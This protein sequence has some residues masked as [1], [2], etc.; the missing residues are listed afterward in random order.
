MKIDMRQ[1]L[2]S[3]FDEAAEHIE[4]MESALLALSET[5]HNAELLNTVFRAAHSIKGASATFDVRSVASFT[6]VLESLLERMRL[7]DVPVTA[8]RIETMLQTIDVLQG[9]LSAEQNGTPP[10]DNVDVLVGKLHAL[11]GTDGDAAATEPVLETRPESSDES[12]EFEIQFTPS[13]RIF[14][15][16]LDPLLLLDDL[17]EC[18]TITEICIDDSRLPELDKMDP[19][20]CYLGWSVRL[21][22]TQ[23]IDTVRDVFVFVDEETR[24]EVTTANCDEQPGQD[25]ETASD[26]GDN[27]TSFSDQTTNADSPT[28]G[29]RSADASL[30]RR[31]SIRVDAGR[32]DKLIN[33]VGELVIGEAMTRQEFFELDPAGDS[34]G[35]S[36]LSRTVTE[37]QEL[38]L[39]LRMVPIAGTFQ[40]TKRI[41]YDVSRKVGKDVVFETEGTETELD[42]TVVDQLGDPLMHMVRNAVDHGIEAANVRRATG[43]PEAGRVVLRA[44]HRSGNVC[45]ELEDDG[46][47]L[48]REAILRKAIERDIVSEADAP[49][50]TDE[51]VWALI[52]APGFSTAATVT[53][54]SGRGVGMDVV[55]RNIEAING[56]ISITSRAGRGSTFHI[57]L[58]LTMAIVDGLAV[59]LSDETFIVPLLAVV[60]SLRPDQEHVKTIKGDGEVVMVRGEPIPLVRPHRVFNHA[61]A[62]A[63]PWEALVVV[64]ENQGRHLALLVDDLEGDVQAVMKSLEDNYRKVDGVAG[65]TILG[66]GQVG[67][68]LDIPGLDRIRRG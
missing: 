28:S 39:S 2:R 33:M 21:K 15:L 27:S 52:F 55:K 1:F 65:A 61:Y 3:F 19:E 54:V 8:E 60:E 63:N 18:G 67:L 25:Q 38:S 9:L 36:L 42:K 26:G 4:R 47:G 49:S 56:T 59:T 23:S 51:E 11:N 24:V 34:Q 50:M 7:G 58:P 16:G 14:H 40:K 45:I 41:V 48:D 12:N 37:L 35:L 43:K 10:P 13:A 6:H 30:A 64:V 17:R 66:D 32:L 22:T 20:N 68:I 46:G 29:T 57:Q 53:D 31:D 5:P 44:F 62:K